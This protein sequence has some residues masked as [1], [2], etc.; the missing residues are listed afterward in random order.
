MEFIDPRKTPFVL[1]HDRGELPHL[2]KPGSFYFIT[3]RLLDAVAVQPRPR[4]RPPM[5]LANPDPHELLG[6]YDPPITLGSCI[7][8]RADIASIL[9]SALLAANSRD[10]QLVR[11][12]IMP[13]HVH[14]I[15][16]PLAEATLPKILQSWKGGTSRLINLQLGRQGPLWERECFDHLVRS[17]EILQR[18]AQYV[19]ENPVLAG[20]CKSPADWPFRSAGT[21]YVFDI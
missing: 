5:D 3:F 6:D 18:F 19:D 9:Q 17:I 1:M 2:Y 8:R 10:Y 12:C 20:L 13:N 4:L 15:V 16:A 11:W 7:L 21:G 14:V